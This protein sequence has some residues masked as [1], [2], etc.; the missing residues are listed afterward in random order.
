MLNTA[1]INEEIRTEYRRIYGDTEAPSKDE[2]SVES[3]VQ[4]QTEAQEETV[5]ATPEEGAAPVLRDATGKFAKSPDSAITEPPKEPAA[6]GASPQSSTPT[7]EDQPTQAPA[8]EASRDI[9]RAPSSWK[10]TAKAAWANLP[11]EIRAEVHRRESDFLKGQSGLLPDAHLGQ[12]MRSVIEPYRAIIDAEG[13]TPERAVA[14]LLRTA[15]LFRMGTAQQKQQALQQIARQYGIS[16]EPDKRPDIQTADGQG[17]NQPTSYQDPRVDQLFQ[18]LQGQENAR[19]HETQKQVESAANSWINESAPD[20]KPLRPYLDDVMPGMNVRV[21]A[22]RSQN[23][24]LSHKEV[25]QQAYEQEIWAN[26]EIRSLLI[27]QQQD[28]ASARSRTENQERV[29]LAKRASS[30]NVPRRGSTLTPAKPGSMAET[31]EKEARRLGLV[32]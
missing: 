31:I 21:P 25:L 26:P 19:Q 2:P 4:G 11:P 32:T 13:G 28:E 29:N 18:Y 30:V 12:S 9:N 14:D 20:G 5:E 6:N 15:A 24:S 10:P 22:I 7:S 23:P 1:N 3:E 16:M 27:K 17:F 8:P